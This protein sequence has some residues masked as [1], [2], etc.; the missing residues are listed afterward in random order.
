[1]TALNGLTRPWDSFFQTICARKESLKF[2]IIWE[3]C[4]K[5]EVR[6]AN[7]EALLRYDDHALATH[8]KRRKGKHNFKKET[9]KG[10]YPPNNFQKNKKGDYKQKDFSTYQCYHCDKIGHIA[11]NCSTNKE[12]YKR[13]NN[14]RHHAKLV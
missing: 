8:T 11:R 7:Q 10:S 5:E 3:E 13:K 12:E 4:V 2:D 1:M 9:H 14:N 6:V